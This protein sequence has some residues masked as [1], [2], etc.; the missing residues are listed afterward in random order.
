MIEAIPQKG[1]I[2][3]NRDCAPMA[4][5]FRFHCLKASIARKFSFQDIRE[6]ISYGSIDLEFPSFW[7]VRPSRASCE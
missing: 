7:M 3:G 2:A 4:A 5:T 6:S 1:R